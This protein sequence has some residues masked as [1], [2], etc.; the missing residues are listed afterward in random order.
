MVQAEPKAH[1]QQQPKDLGEQKV[2]VKQEL[3]G[4]GAEPK[5]HKKDK[6]NEKHKEA[7]P[8]KERK[9]DKSEKTEK[10][11]KQDK[12]QE[13]QQGTKRRAPS[14][15]F[16]RKQ[17]MAWAAARQLQPTAAA[18]PTRAVPE[19][20]NSSSSSLQLAPAAAPPPTANPS[21]AEAAAAAAAPP[22]APPPAPAPAAAPGAAGGSAAEKKGV[23][24]FAPKYS[25]EEQEWLKGEIRKF[26]ELPA[27]KWLREMKREGEELGKLTTVLDYEGFRQACRT[28]AAK[29]NK[30]AAV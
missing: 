5:K 30:E 19:N 23:F 1:P 3:D 2:V 29:V 26:G 17:H 21:A 12:D 22:A 9:K 18:P 8:K 7:K 24:G 27:A 11:P 10:G 25:L 6:N 16:I 15:A 20:S 4:L 28:L 13:R 14:F